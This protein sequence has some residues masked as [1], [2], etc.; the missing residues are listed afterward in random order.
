MHL[1]SSSSIFSTWSSVPTSASS[2]CMF[3][4]SE[5]ESGGADACNK[6]TFIEVIEYTASCVTISDDDGGGE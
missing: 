3:S 2:C 4:S 6:S 1:L 5:S